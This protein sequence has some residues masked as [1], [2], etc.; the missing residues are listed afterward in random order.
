MFKFTGNRLCGASPHIR[1]F[2]RSTGRKHLMIALIKLFPCTIG[3]AILFYGIYT[4]ICYANPYWYSYFVIGSFLFFDRLDAFLNKDSNLTRLLRGSW[5]PLFF[6]YSI[7]VIAALI[8]D[9]LMGRFLSNMIIYPHFDASDRVIHVILIGYPFAFLSC[10]ALYR[11]LAGVF[12]RFLGRKPTPIILKKSYLPQLAGILLFGTIL[13]VALPLLNYMFFKNKNVHELMIICLFIGVLSLSPIKLLHRKS[14][15]LANLLSGDLGAIFSLLLSI[16]VNA[17]AHEV[18]N[19]YAWEWSYQYIPFTS[20]EIL[21]VNI[22]V[23]TVGWTCLT[24]LGI[25]GNDLFFSSD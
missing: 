17:F 6:T 21:N 1:Y 8:I 22:I 25:S 15:F 14:C 12:Y 4:A 16:P 19:T 2:L 7:F 3:C 20:L 9:L 13:S 18:P 24:V 23:F 5:Q 10:S 11:F